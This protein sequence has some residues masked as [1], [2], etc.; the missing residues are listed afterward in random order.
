MQ[1]GARPHVGFSFKHLLNQQFGVR[2]TSR[3]FPFPWLPRFPDLASKDFW[4]WIFV[5]SKVYQFHPQ[6]RPDFKGAIKTAIEEIPI[7]M[8][9]TAVLSTNCRLQIVT[10]SEGKHEKNL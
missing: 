4:L 2:I 5:K 7:A 3:H 8:I 9:R 1:D 6:T 10:V